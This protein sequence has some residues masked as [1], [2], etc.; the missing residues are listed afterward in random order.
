[1]YV[2]SNYGS[3]FGFNR[4]LD[5]A[6]PASL[7]WE[8]GHLEANLALRNADLMSNSSTEYLCFI[9]HQVLDILGCRSRCLAGYPPGGKSGHY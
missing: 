6:K 2:S 5:V 8:R 9:A 1:M 3:C 4:K 7:G